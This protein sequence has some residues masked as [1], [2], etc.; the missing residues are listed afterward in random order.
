MEIDKLTRKVNKLEK[1]IK[2]KKIKKKQ[3]NCFHKN[4]CFSKNIKF[5]VQMPNEKKCFK[6]RKH[7]KRKLNLLKNRYKIN[8]VVK[9]DKNNEWQ[10][11]DYAKPRKRKLNLDKESNLLSKGRKY[12]NNKVDLFESSE[13]CIHSVISKDYLNK[14]FCKSEK[15]F[16]SSKF[17]DRVR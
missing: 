6:Y 5:I 15:S 1:L 3:K 9:G 2:K 8:H 13:A 11:E 10:I 4:C 16:T 12:F 17:S 14:D 7:E